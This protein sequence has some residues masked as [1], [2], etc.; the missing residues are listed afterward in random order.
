MGEQTAKET[1][2]PEADKKSY[3]SPRFTIYGNLA[4]LTGATGGN[5]G[6]DSAQVGSSMSTN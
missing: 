4:H 5:M 3:T 6:K 2:R 1:R